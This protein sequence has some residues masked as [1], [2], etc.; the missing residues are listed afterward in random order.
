MG[1]QTRFMKAEDINLAEMLT[2]EPEAG[3][4]HLGGDRMLIFRQDSLAELRRL[5]YDQLGASLA[6]SVLSRFGYQCGK[7]DFENLQKNY[8]WDTEAD[9]IDAGPTMHR[10][11]GIVNIQPTHVEFDRETG[12][13]HGT[14]IWQ[15]S[16]EA[17]IHR[18]RFGV[19]DTPACYTLAG[20]ASGYGSA[21][22]GRP[23]LAVE[24]QC[25]ACGHD[26]CEAEIRTADAWGPEAR[27][28]LEALESSDYSLSRELERKLEVIERQ[29]AA[30]SELSTPIMEVWED[31]LVLPIV[32][33]ID[34]RRSID[35]ME[36]LLDT[37]VAKQARCVIIDVTGVEVVDTKTADYL[38]KIV[39]AA[40]LLG[41]RCVLTGLSPAV[42]QT[43]AEIGTDLQGVLTL[44][45]LKEGLEDCLRFL[46]SPV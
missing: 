30:L 31:V 29:A 45:S 12:H 18:A 14:V 36:K 24:T 19:S 10:W 5:L 17:E 46:G 2:F 23:V 37:I 15:N 4:L 38:V 34:T 44:R 22:M 28:W 1:Y 21:F 41:S 39:R 9:S 13:F 16:Y 6:R 35:I 11:E 43:L 25:M 40:A 33:I 32:G 26:H 3:R 20:Y 27:P 7:G 42:A 8:E